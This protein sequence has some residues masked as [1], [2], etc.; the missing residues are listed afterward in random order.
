MKGRTNNFTVNKNT[1]TCK[2]CGRPKL[3]LKK[4]Y[5]GSTCTIRALRIA[6]SSTTTY[7]S[8]RSSLHQLVTF[9]YD[10]S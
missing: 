8:E 4:M 2:G 6:A 9:P 1:T 3:Y 7:S 5:R 10:Y